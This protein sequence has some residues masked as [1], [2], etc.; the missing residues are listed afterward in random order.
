MADREDGHPER[1]A[2]RFAEAF[3]DHE[4]GRA[5]SDSSAGS[6]GAE[7]VTAA[8]GRE[9][10]TALLG[11]LWARATGEPLP[12]AYEFRMRPNP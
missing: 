10:V 4:T 2:E 7:A 6:G 3:T 12:G 11:E 8:L 1:A 5:G 9:A